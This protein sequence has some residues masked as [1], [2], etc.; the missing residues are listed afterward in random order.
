MVTIIK[1]CGVTM[2]KKGKKVYNRQNQGP[3]IFPT[4]KEF[5][6]LSD[7]EIIF[8]NQLHWIPLTITSILY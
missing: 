7:A 8:E 1:A 5:S 4:E 3:Y 6:Y 2:Y